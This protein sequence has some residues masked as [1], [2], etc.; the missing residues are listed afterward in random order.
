[1]ETRVANAEGLGA[2]AR[3]LSFPCCGTLLARGLS[4]EGSLV[5]SASSFTRQG[6]FRVYKANTVGENACLTLKLAHSCAYQC[7][8][9]M[10]SPAANNAWMKWQTK[11]DWEPGTSQLLVSHAAT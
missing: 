10:C 2:G 8:E 9:L 11:M 3:Q 1:M 5:G 7:S 6:F 4:A